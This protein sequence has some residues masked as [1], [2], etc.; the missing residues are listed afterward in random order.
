MRVLSLLLT[1]STLFSASNAF[2]GT[3]GIF[4]IPSHEF[5][6][7]D[8]HG[9]VRIPKATLEELIQNSN[10][11]DTV[12]VCDTAFKIDLIHDDTSIEILNEE[13]EQSATLVS[14]DSE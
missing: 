7:T 13:A 5:K 3:I 8:V 14:A 11:G 9:V 4:K 10:E 2:C 6:S 12:L 1:I